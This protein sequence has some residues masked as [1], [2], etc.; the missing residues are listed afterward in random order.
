MKLWMDFHDNSFSSFRVYNVQ[1]DRMGDGWWPE[2]ENIFFFS[3]CIIGMNGSRQVI[4]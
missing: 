4:Y 1:L 3:Y 2:R